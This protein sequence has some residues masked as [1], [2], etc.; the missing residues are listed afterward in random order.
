MEV[1]I[2]DSSKYKGI[3]NYAKNFMEEEDVRIVSFGDSYNDI[4]MFENSYKSYVMSSA[5][6][7]VKKHATDETDST[8]NDGLL[9]GINH[10]YENYNI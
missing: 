1:S 2:P 4:E 3:V 5:V 9:K 6:K 8:Q 10:F 7:D